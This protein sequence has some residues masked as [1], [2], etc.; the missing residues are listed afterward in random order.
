MFFDYYF[1]KDNSTADKNRIVFV[2][3]QTVDS[4]SLQKSTLSRYKSHRTSSSN[5]HNQQD[6]PQKTQTGKA[7]NAVKDEFQKHFTF[8]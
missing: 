2:N 5:G 8:L 6:R 1:M 3:T 7:Y 4:I